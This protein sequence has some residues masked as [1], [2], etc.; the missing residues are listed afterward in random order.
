MKNK[1][2]CSL[3]NYLEQ[4]LA[5]LLT[6]TVP[7]ILIRIELYD[8]LTFISIM[9]FSICYPMHYMILIS[10]YVY[11]CPCADSPVPRT[12]MASSDIS[13]AHMGP[14]FGDVRR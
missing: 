6:C 10:L 2:L 3:L 13:K 5:T 1:K 9:I 14:P 11:V 8:C 7:L 12:S 4:L